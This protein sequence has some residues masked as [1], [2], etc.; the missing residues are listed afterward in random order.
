MDR[1]VKR[2][3]SAIQSALLYYLQTQ[4]LQRISVAQ[5]IQRADISRSTFYLHYEDI[6]DLYNHL[7]SEAIDDL[8]KQTADNY[9][10]TSRG[11]YSDLATMYIEYIVQHQDI[12]KLITQS[13]DHAAI[14]HLK[15]EIVKTV[16]SLS[17]ENL[18]PKDPQDYYDTV[19]SVNGVIGVLSDWLNHGEISKEE[20]ITIVTNIIT[21]I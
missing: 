9:P 18:N 4:P 21:R 1:R 16:L 15:S 12:F 19:C 7:V 5:I 3:K 13:S 6:Y 8:L 14:E 11:S 20:L 2:T 17:L 10:V